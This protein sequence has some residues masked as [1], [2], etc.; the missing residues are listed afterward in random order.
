MGEMRLK[1]CEPFVL[2]AI[3]VG[4]GEGNV[5]TRR[6]VQEDTT[7]ANEADRLIEQ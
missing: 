1:A 2:R 7:G 6:I 4:D 5:L 3:V